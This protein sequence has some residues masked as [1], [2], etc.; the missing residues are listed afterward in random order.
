MNKFYK[1]GETAEMLG[2]TTTTLR[3]WEWYKL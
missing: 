2:V 3:D 1:I